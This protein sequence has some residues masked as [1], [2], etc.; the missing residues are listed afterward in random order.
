[1]DF[2]DF[3]YRQ[4]EKDVEDKK[5]NLDFEEYYYYTLYNENGICIL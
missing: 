2:R 1:M 3:V 5:T 4:W